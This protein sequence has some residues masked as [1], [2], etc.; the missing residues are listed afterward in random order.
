M[1]LAIPYPNIDP[2]LFSIG[3]LVIRWYALAYIFGLLLAWWYVRWLVSRTPHA[4][5][6][7]QVDDFLTWVMVGVVLGGRIGYVLFYKFNF[8]LSDPM[9]AL[10]IWEGG[11]SF[12]GGLIGSAIAGILF[13]KRRGIR[14]LPFADVLFSAAPIGLFLGRL[15]NFIN[16]ELYGRVSDVPWAFVFPRGGDY[17]RHPSQLYEAALE[18]VL[19]FIVLHVLW[20][21]EVVRNRP[22]ILA[23]VFLLGYGL[24]RAAVELFRQPDAHLGFLLGGSTMGQWLS[25][26]MMAVGIYLI[27]SAKRLIQSSD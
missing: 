13:A 27:I 22:G 23:G 1:I 16:G 10:R 11:M 2:V 15:A 14:M 18:G 4:A 7:G 12:H 6:K 8:Y 17:P 26:P 21:S 5:S 3:P 20:R 24:S 25:A 19:L 9:A